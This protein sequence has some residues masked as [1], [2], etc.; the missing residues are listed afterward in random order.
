[1]RGG[2]PIIF[3]PTFG[4][5]VLGGVGFHQPLGGHAA[6]VAEIDYTY[7][8]TESFRQSAPGGKIDLHAGVQTYF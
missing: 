7:Y 2:V 6:F 4:L 8:L 1:M 3:I 5:G